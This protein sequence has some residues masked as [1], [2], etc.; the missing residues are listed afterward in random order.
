MKSH[1]RKFRREWGHLFHGWR[2]SFLP[3][4]LEHPHLLSDINIQSVGHIQKKEYF[5][6]GSR[7]PRY[8]IVY[9]VNGTGTYQVSSGKVYS[10]QPGTVFTVWP[11]ATFNYGPTSGERW[12]EYYLSFYG[13]RVNQWI[14]QGLFPKDPPIHTVGVMKDQIQRFKRILEVCSKPQSGIFDYVIPLVEELLIHFAHKLILHHQEIPDNSI[15]AIL[16]M[17]RNDLDK[18]L[19]FMGIAQKAGMSYSKLRQNFK[20]ITGFPPQDYLNRVRVT[21]AKQLLCDPSLSVKMIGN[22]IGIDD[23]YYFST[24]FRRYAGIS[25]RQFRDQIK[26]FKSSVKKRK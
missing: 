6:R 5:H 24:V 7:F 11:G 9:I 4:E 12:E 13:P 25:P 14:S 8:S 10:V 21:K 18:P 22:K 3:A 16:A 23:P 15:E 20:R 1:N 2:Q 17:I 26:T 19:D